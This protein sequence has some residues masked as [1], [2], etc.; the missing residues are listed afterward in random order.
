[1]SSTNK[2]LSCSAL[3]LFCILSHSNDSFC[4]VYFVLSFIQVYRSIIIQKEACE[5]W[6][7]ISSRN[8]IWTMIMPSIHIIEE[9][10]KNHTHTYFL[11]RNFYLVRR[12][13]LSTI[14]LFGFYFVSVPSQ[15]AC[16]CMCT[17]D[18]FLS[19]L[20]NDL[21]QHEMTIF[22]NNIYRLK[23][24]WLQCM[25][26]IDEIWTDSNVIVFGI[27]IINGGQWATIVLKTMF[28]FSFE[29]KT[30]VNIMTTGD[31]NYYLFTLG[32]GEYYLL[33]IMS[34]YSSS[35]LNIG[36]TCNDWSCPHKK[37]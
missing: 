19:C 15:N 29:S 3:F 20:C 21:V 4:F 6:C 16:A 28:S 34:L 24:L 1:M 30:T 8:R 33:C 17:C 31:S 25:Y 5:C 36:R 18:N 22:P 35:H 12:G 13:R 14:V 37:I 26:N 27:T 9:A 32:M 23:G 11:G 7:M 2:T 10:I